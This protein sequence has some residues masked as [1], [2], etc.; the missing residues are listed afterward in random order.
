MQD[1]WRLFAAIEL[2]EPVRERVAQVAQTLARAGWR[3]T[4]VDSQ[5]S[6][7]TL[8]FYG[9]VARD[10]IPALSQALRRA[11]SGSEPF[12]LQVAGAGVFPNP[13]RPRVLWLGLDADLDALA[14]LQREVERLSAD[15]GYLPEERDY[16][17]HV[18]V[19]RIRPEDLGT[20]TEVERHLAEIAELPPLP[21][22]VERV[23]LFRSQLR[24]GG[25]VYSVVEQFPLKG[26]AA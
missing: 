12:M 3:A 9:N 14:R 22:P 16:H 24:R 15:L 21:C 11:A 26:H 19:A 5:G 23:T 25:A 6:H 17:P 18:T 7:L 20:I 13:R 4:W 8:K 2:S 10:R 1:V